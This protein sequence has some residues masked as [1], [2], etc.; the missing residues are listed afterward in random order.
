MYIINYFA[1]AF[2]QKIMDN[3]TSSEKMIPLKKNIIRNIQMVTNDYSIEKISLAIDE[4][5]SATNETDEQI[6]TRVVMKQLLD[7]ANQTSKKK[8]T[9]PKQKPLTS[10]MVN[11]IIG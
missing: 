11:Y 3:N 1:A 6:L 7:K 10:D 8:R 2:T 4:V 9:S 5:L